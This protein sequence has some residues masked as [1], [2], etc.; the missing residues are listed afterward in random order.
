MKVGFCRATDKVI[1][2]SYGPHFGE[3]GNIISN[4]KLADIMLLHKN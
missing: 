1:V 4:E 2:S 3:E